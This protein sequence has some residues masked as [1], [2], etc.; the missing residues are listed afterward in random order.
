L[1]LRGRRFKVDVTSELHETDV[2][3][4][5]HSAMN[6]KAH[7]SADDEGYSHMGMR[8]NDSDDPQTPRRWAFL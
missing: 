3:R 5:L 8:N 2:T 1:L 7:V 4:E 6:R